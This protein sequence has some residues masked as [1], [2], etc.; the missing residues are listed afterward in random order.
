VVRTGIALGADLV[1]DGEAAASAV[2]ERLRTA[3]ASAGIRSIPWRGAVAA[4]LAIAA[5]VVLTISLRPTGHRPALPMADSAVVALLRELQ[6]L[7]E[8]QL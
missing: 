5:S 3:D 4:A 1:V 2:L 7:D 8:S 6:S